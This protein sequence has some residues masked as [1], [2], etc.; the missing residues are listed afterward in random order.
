[1]EF[2]FELLFE[3]VLQVLFEVV[4]EVAFRGMVDTLKKPKV[5]GLSPVGYLMGYLTWGG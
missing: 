4:A 5:S 3:L 2:L 1:M